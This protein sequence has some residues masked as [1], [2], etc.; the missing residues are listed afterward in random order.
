MN[1]T[2]TEELSKLFFVGQLTLYDA[3]ERRKLWVIQNK[4]S[5]KGTQTEREKLMMRLF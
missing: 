4:I 3:F 1:K 2:K 5:K